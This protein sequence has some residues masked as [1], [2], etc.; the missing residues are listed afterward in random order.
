MEGGASF[1]PQQV[2]LNRVSSPDEV[3]NDSM[4]MEIKATMK[5]VFLMLAG[6]VL[7]GTA[8][9]GTSQDSGHI[10]ELYTSSTGSIAI[11]LD[12][13]FPNSVAAGQ[14]TTANG[15]AGNTT[16]DN[17]LKAT[18]MTAKATGATVLVSTSGCDA[19]GY[20]LKITEVYIK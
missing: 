7:S 11:L 17:A 2:A 8:L 16:A 3:A 1:A 14:C 13:G 12:G 5:Q 20:W 18:L 10:T 15:F 9:A 19:S 4:K 6:M